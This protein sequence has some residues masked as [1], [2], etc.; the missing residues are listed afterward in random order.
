MN[1]AFKNRFQ[2]EISSR[3][4][5]EGDPKHF[6]NPK[7]ENQKRNNKWKCFLCCYGHQQG[8]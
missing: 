7:E 3:D 1:G 8:E 2:N 4:P 5:N 6:G